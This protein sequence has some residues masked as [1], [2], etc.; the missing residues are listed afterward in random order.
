MDFQGCGRAF[1]PV[2]TKMNSKPL[3]QIE[4]LF[5]V[6]LMF[7]NYWIKSM[8]QFPAFVFMV[9][10]N[11]WIRE[12]NILISFILCDH[13]TLMK[14]CLSFSTV[15]ILMFLLSIILMTLLQLLSI[16]GTNIKSS[17][18]SLLTFFLLSSWWCFDLVT[19]KTKGR[20]GIA[21][22]G[23]RGQWE[24]LLAFQWF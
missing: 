6:A 18:K 9:K 2:D 22:S 17:K 5:Y 15:D 12:V 13:K 21:Q 11:Q 14:S 19:V 10:T 4:Q 3:L 24:H 16:P 8:M 23:C 1:F 7:L 20:Y